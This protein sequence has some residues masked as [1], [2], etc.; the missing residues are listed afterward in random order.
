MATHYCNRAC[1]LEHWPK[2]KIPCKSSPIYRASQEVAVSVYEIGDNLR[3]QGKLKET[4]PYFRRS[5]EGYERVHGPDHPGTLMS[6]NNLDTLL[7]SQ[8]KLDL[9][10]PY[11]HRALEGRERTL[12]LDHQNTLNSVGNMGH[13]LR[14]QGKLSL[15]EPFVRR[16]AAL[17]RDVRRLW[18]TITPTRSLR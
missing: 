18:G 2:H 14:A 1:Q 3:S 17:S 10:K 4:E 15:A 16:F 9:A 12:G 8:G 7:Q 13:L 6:V 11:Y 5:L